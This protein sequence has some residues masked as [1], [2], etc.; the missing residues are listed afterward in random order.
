MAVDRVITD[1][2]TM[3]WQNGTTNT[4]LPT[5]VRTKL[6]SVDPA[7]GARNLLLSLPPG[8]VEPRPVEGVHHA[9][10]LL[11]GRWFAA[12]KEVGPGGYMSGP[13]EFPHAPL[14]AP[15][16]CLVYTSVMPSL[17]HQ[18]GVSTTVVVDPAEVE[19]EEGAPESPALPAGVFRK[20]YNVDPVTDRMDMLIR[21]EPGYV[22]PRHVHRQTHYDTVLEGRWII[23][24]TEVTQG[25]HIF[26]PPD[27]PHGPFECPD[28]VL[29]CV[30]GFGD[31]H[32]HLV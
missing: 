6:L 2:K 17:D 24:G 14:V 28:G 29:V 7:V 23:E 18:A 10:F 19:W 21:F 9:T 26:G 1:P 13:G 15:E 22:E 11:Q 20:V 12:G 16:G 4:E 27:V 32:H 5:G 3:E 25:G 31:R 8:A 30:S